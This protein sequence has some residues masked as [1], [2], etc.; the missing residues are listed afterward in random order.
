MWRTNRSKKRSDHRA[1]ALEMLEGRLLMSGTADALLWQNLGSFDTHNSITTLPEAHDFYGDPQLG[2]GPAVHHASEATLEKSIS[3]VQRSLPSTSG[4][5]LYLEFGGATVASRP[6]DFYLGSESIEIAPFNLETFGW[7]GQESNAAEHILGFVSEDF[8]AYDVTVTAT[9]PANSNFTTIYVGGDNEWYNPGS[10]VIGVA[11]YDSKNKDSSNYGFAFTEELGAYA[12][13]SNGDLV[14]FTEYVSNLVSHEAGHTFGLPHVNDRGYIMN[15]FLARNSLTQG[16]GS[17]DNVDN[18]EKLGLNVGYLDG[19]TDDIGDSQ[20]NGLDISGSATVNGRIEN[21]NDVDAFN[22]SV[23]VLSTL[24][25]EV[26][27]GTY[28]NLDGELTVYRND[29]GAMVVTNNDSGGGRDPQVTFVAESDITY[30][31]YLNSYNNQN[32]GSYALSVSEVEVPPE[33]IYPPS[34][35]PLELMP[36]T[37][38][39]LNHAGD[40]VHADSVANGTADVHLFSVDQIGSVVIHVVSESLSGQMAVYDK[41]G[42]F[43]HSGAQM[44]QT[45]PAGAYYLWVAG[46]DS[47]EGGAYAVSIDAPWSQR[48][49]AEVNEA[50]DATLTGMIMHVGDDA[51][52]TLVGPQYSDGNLTVG[53]SAGSQDLAVRLYNTSGNLVEYV[54]ASDEGAE[55]LTLRNVGSGVTYYAAVSDADGD[56][57]PITLAVDFGIHVPESEISLV[58][59][60]G[61]AN[62]NHLQFGTV[63]IHQT[64]TQ[65]LQ[66]RNSG[67]AILSVDIDEL[68]SPYFVSM[69]S[70]PISGP[71]EV[72]AGAMVELLVHIHSTSDGEFEES[73][74]LSTNDQDEQ[75]I[76]IALSG[77][78]ATPALSYLEFDS[79]T[80]QNLS[81]GHIEVG[82]TTSISA[83]RITNNGSADAQV[84]FAWASG[85]DFSLA[86]NPARTIAAGEIALIQIDAHPWASGNLSDTLQITTTDPTLPNISYAVTATG[87]LEVNTGK[88]I[89]F[90]DGGGDMVRLHLSGPGTIQVVLG[91]DNNSGG[92][93]IDSLTLT[94]TGANS[95]VRIVT[96]TGDLTTVNSLVVN[97]K[98]RH[99]RASNLYIVSSLQIDGDVGGRVTIGGTGPSSVAS[100]DGLVKNVTVTGIAQGSWN[101]N[102]AVSTFTA[103]TDINT[104]A[105]QMTEVRRFNARGN[106]TAETITLDSVDRFYVN[107]NFNSNSLAITNVNQLVVKG[108][109]DSTVSANVVGR[110]RFGS[111]NGS[112][113]A[114]RMTQLDVNGN[115]NGDLD[116][117]TVDKLSIRGNASGNWDLGTVN[118]ILVR[119]S[120]S[121]RMVTPL[122]ALDSFRAGALTGA[123]IAVQGSLSN[124]IVS[125]NV[126]NSTI[127]VQ[128]I[129]RANFRGTMTDSTLNANAIGALRVDAISGGSLTV[130]TLGRLNVRKGDLASDVTIADT[131][132]LRVRGS[133]SGT[134][135]LQSDVD[136]VHIGKDLSGKLNVDGSLD[137]LYVRGDLTG[138]VDVIGE[139]LRTT[140]R[141]VNTGVNVD[142]QPTDSTGDA[143]DLLLGLGA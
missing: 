37:A 143:V 40:L 67:D 114:A 79:V 56:T 139:L 59:T 12:N 1:P 10:K 61:T 140:V 31:A 98:L 100:F 71:I 8:S 88:R 24:T 7:A 17:D 142:G 69:N 117:N 125:G 86:G 52:F 28:G 2:Y 134:V 23:G 70:A 46:S 30:T 18:Q 14:R 116:A 58:E 4:Q 44:D 131:D 126:T 74:T 45:L 48:D 63:A 47:S 123:G 15:S 129:T 90:I 42:D 99:L 35:L 41:N 111:F 115:W 27:T 54:D 3:A 33:P 109:V 133:I 66:I 22:I 112:F 5:V 25:L 55:T 68:N 119:E 34:Q 62:D 124:L 106:V 118:R 43:V 84:E 9:L 94:G 16:F 89:S 105:F 60:S 137:R 29:T 50:G 57:G 130:A 97:G 72:A 121:V 36:N 19:V 11:T 80:D 64:E 132:R 78:A 95:T 13:V 73:L 75:H 104:A 77:E 53:V 127:D 76:V 32:N 20:S 81:L 120:F 91:G 38:L 96:P 49:V 85:S 103:R 87:F 128:N 136:S 122:D 51:Y 113:D 21:L 6:G 92:A 82:T 110:A 26:D 101:F 102:N 83:L 93:D 138:T 65:V 107:G 141:G 135:R 108:T 39:H